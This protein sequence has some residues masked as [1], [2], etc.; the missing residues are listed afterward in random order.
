MTPNHRPALAATFTAL[1]L[2]ALGTLGWAAAGTAGLLLPALVA[3][4]GFQIPKDRY[5]HPSRT[6]LVL[7]QTLPLAAV[8][9]LPFVVCLLAGW[10]VSTALA[11]AMA[12]VLALSPPVGKCREHAYPLPLVLVSCAALAMVVWVMAV[13]LTSSATPRF[14]AQWRPFVDAYGP[15][16]FAAGFLSF[17]GLMPLLTVGERHHTFRMSRQEI[18]RWLVL[19]AGYGG[20]SGLVLG[21]T[22]P[23]PSPSPV[24]LWTVCGV[25]TGMAVAAVDAL[26]Q[27]WL[28]AMTWVL[29]KVPLAELERARIETAI[30]LGDALAAANAQ[31]PGWELVWRRDYDRY[32]TEYGHPLRFE[33]NRNGGGWGP[34]PDEAKK[35]LEDAH[36][37]L[38]TTF[39]AYTQT[40][41][42][43]GTTRIAALTA[44]A[45]MDALARVNSAQRT[46]A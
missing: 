40:H 26:R 37:H 4:T 25:A 17:A 32:D 22:D 19:G 13:G 15:W 43:T 20:V 5:R 24:V 34:T 21:L 7:W 33:I 38:D 30:A 35:V 44:H 41:D 14:F 29:P 42:D 45:K 6:G 16:M 18:L 1:C 36:A 27:P 11:P 9:L 10:P 3:I 28:L 46:A 39:G 23:F 8:G 31:F 2:A 12:A